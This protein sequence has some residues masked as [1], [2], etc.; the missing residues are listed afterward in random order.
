MKTITLLLAL[1]WA[2]SAF[3]QAFYTQSFGTGTGFPAGWSS[4]DTR[5]ALSASV[6]SSGYHRSSAS[7]EASGG[8]NVNFQE[9]SPNSGVILYLQ[10]SGVI[11]TS[12]KSNIRIGFGRRKTAAFDK[13]VSLEYSTDG[14]NWTLVDEDV[15]T[16]AS[17]A[18]EAVFYDLSAQTE[19]VSNLR[20]RFGYVSDVNH[21]C[22]AAPN[23]RMDDFTVGQN[24]SLPVTLLDFNATLIDGKV[25]LSWATATEQQSDRF[26][27]ERSRNGITFEEIASIK[28][29]GTS[30]ETNTYTFRDEQ[31]LPGS[32]YYR[33]RQVDFD[34][35]YEYGPVKTVKVGGGPQVSLSPVPAREILT[36]SLEGSFDADANWNIIDLQ[37]NSQL[38]G[39]LPAETTALDIPVAGLPPGMYFLQV[40]SGVEVVCVCFLVR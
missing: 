32:N 9:C 11:N 30:Y 19:G 12:G 1:F 10:C 7:P 39:L 34:G 3:S 18:W 37:G 31:P 28:A 35:K 33:L 27:L 17:D 26:A 20:F 14:S 8:N 36:L 2:S 25:Q 24:A 40:V 38:R 16:G 15:T 22:T 29:A 21:N 5:I 23:F 4:T 13:P 6:P